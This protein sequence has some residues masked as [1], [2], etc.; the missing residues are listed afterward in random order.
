MVR[1]LPLLQESAP[2]IIASEVFALIERT[3]D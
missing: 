1:N 3:K 2:T